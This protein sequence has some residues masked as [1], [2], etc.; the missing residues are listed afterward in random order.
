MAKIID[1]HEVKKMTQD[2]ASRKA[3]YE[4]LWRAGH[5]NEKDRPMPAPPSDKYIQEELVR[6]LL[7]KRK[8][9]F[10]LF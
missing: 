1:E 2:A 9:F 5:A 10:G 3:L 4:I 8:K 6:I 7:P